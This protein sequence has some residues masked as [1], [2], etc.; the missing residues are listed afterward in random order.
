MSRTL[1][2]HLGANKTG[3]TAIQEFLRLN[4][5]ALLQQGIHV[6]SGD[7][8]AG[9]AVTGQQAPYIEQLVADP[10]AGGGEM[11]TRIDSLMDTIP[12]GATLV[13]S[14]ENLSNPGN[15]SP[16]LFAGVSGKYQA[17]ALL[18]IRRPD[19]FLLS[20][21]RQWY[22]KVLDDFWAWIV[23]AAGRRCD[24]RMI[25]AGW[26]QVIP[27]DR[28]MVR[29]YDRAR[30]V[31]RDVISDFLSVLGIKDEG[32]ERPQG[33]INP[34]YS[35][36][37]QA[38]VGANPLLF[39]DL[40]DD[41][42]YRIVD[43][44]TGSRFHRNSRESEITHEQRLALLQRYDDANEWV[45]VNYFPTHP[46]PLFAPPQPQDYDV[47]SPERLEQQRWEVAASLI[48]GLSRKVLARPRSSET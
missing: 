19:E 27:R 12:D 17:R 44:L 29:L 10:A 2:L 39:R 3:S 8:L 15:G 23:T 24:W 20:S 35:G 6:A 14:A 16:Q 43:A 4:A 48:Y 1:F 33:N 13:L 40:H 5:E 37:V 18:Y 42:T 32:F 47:M 7:L 30:L 28:M 9:G 11:T 38:L 45:R 25:L 41:D 21:W 46:A 36:A 34:S 31:N 26:E 22:S